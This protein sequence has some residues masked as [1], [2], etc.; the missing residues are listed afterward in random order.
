MNFQTVGEPVRGLLEKAE[1]SL[2]DLPALV[3]PAAVE[4]LPQ[5]V[6]IAKN[7]TLRQFGRTIKMYV[8]LYLSSF[9]ENNCAYCNFNQQNS[10]ARKRLTLDEARQEA[11]LLYGFGF[12]HILLVAGEDRVLIT[13]DYLSALIKKLKEK[14]SSVSIEV[15]P[16][17]TQGYQQLAAAGLDGLTIYQ[18][19]YDRQ[20][21]Q[22]MHAKGRK[23]D[24][25]YR[26]QTPE[27][28]GEANLR[29]IGIGFLLGLADWR[30][31]AISLAQHADFLIKRYWRSQLSISFPRIQKI[32]ANFIPPYFVSDQDFIQLLVA[33]RLVFPHVDLTLSTRES[34]NFRDQLIGIGITRMSAASSTVPG[35]YSNPQKFGG[36]FKV[37]DG[38]SADQV[39]AAISGTGYDPVFKDWESI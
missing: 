34:Q 38:R 37:S 9:C 31:E 3:S 22:S 25:D 30:L 5:L 20:V 23:N 12:R 14:F 16:Q 24:F 13:L 15:A 26:L 4:F 10:T 28:G 29:E 21:Y 8:P 6:E 33:L 17:S 7:K 19:T 35:G 18:E 39:A 27:R 11:D 36:Q 1:F 32:E 2:G